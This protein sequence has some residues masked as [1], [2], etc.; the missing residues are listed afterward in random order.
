MAAR[1]CD[2]NYDIKGQLG[3][4]AFGKVRKADERAAAR[5]AIKIVPATEGEDITQKLNP[6]SCPNYSINYVYDTD[7]ELNVNKIIAR[8]WRA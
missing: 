3:S 5:R 6:N 1:S 7:C 4:G 8:P 2:A